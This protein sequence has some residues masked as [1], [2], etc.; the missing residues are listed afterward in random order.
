MSTDSEASKLSRW[1]LIPIS[2]VI[3]LLLGWLARRRVSGGVR[4]FFKVF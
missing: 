3:S 2:A 4:R 1:R